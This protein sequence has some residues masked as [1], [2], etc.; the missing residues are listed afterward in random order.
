MR[1]QIIGP[2][3]WR[4]SVT[5]TLQTTVSIPYQFEAEVLIRLEQILALLHI[6]PTPTSLNF[7]AVVL[8]G[9]DEIITF[10]QAQKTKTKPV[11]I[12][13]GNRL[14]VVKG[15]LMV[16]TPTYTLNNDAIVY[17]VIN[18]EDAAGTVVPAPSGDT[19]SITMGP[20]TA[21]SG[22]G[23]PLNAVIGV[24]PATLSNGTTPPNAGAP[25]WIYNAL[26][27]TFSGVLVTVSDADGE[28]AYMETV[29]GVA[30]LAPTTIV[31]GGRIMDTQPV[32][33][34]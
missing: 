9:L 27:M 13:A 29:N 25:C 28:T 24:V 10:L 17:T 22:T 12:V 4:I 34:M 18:V 20:P 1:W 26:N 14:I 7:E 15:H 21:Q 2:L 32:P 11:R 5:L 33:T 23:N 3:D 8:A 31:A 30:D 6:A 16:T 19:Y